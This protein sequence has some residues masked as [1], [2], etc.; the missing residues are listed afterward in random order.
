MSNKAPS[1]NIVK[2]KNKIVVYLY[3]YKHVP[4][5]TKL[6]IYACVPLF[7]KHLWT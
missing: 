5:Y 6:N 3:I 4:T 1:L 2:T 7:V